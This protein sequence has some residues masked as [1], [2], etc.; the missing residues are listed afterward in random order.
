ML[1]AKFYAIH[2]PIFDNTQMRALPAAYDE[3][4][5]DHNTLPKELYVLNIK[6]N[7]S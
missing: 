3:L 1:F 7:I 2:T 4:A 6:R 5:V